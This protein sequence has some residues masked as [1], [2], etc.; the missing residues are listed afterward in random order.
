MTNLEWVKDL[1]VNESCKKRLEQMCFIAASVGSEA[2]QFNL[3]LKEL[4]KM[5]SCEIQEIFNRYY[6]HKAN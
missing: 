3:K 5:E 2:I 1:K 4:R 6:E